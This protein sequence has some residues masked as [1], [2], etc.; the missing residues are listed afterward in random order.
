MGTPPMDGNN[1]E[2][3]L[4]RM[5]AHE[6]RHRAAIAADAAKAPRVTATRVVSRPWWARPYVVEQQVDSCPEWQHVESFTDEHRARSA[7]EWLLEG[8]RVTHTFGKPTPNTDQ[9]N[10]DNGEAT[11]TDPQPHR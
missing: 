4:E 6:R 5:R 7:A 11:R 9:E 8:E 3:S 2:A 10:P 1:L